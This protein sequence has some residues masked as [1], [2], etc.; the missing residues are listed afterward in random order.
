MFNFVADI[1]PGILGELVYGG[2]KNQ[3]NQINDATLTRFQDIPQIGANHL[4]VQYWGKSWILH[5]KK[6]YNYTI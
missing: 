4:V 3:E 6:D 1:N 5:L 2:T